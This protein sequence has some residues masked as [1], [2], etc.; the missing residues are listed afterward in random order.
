[1][2]L[3]SGWISYLKNSKIEKSELKLPGSYW[4][5]LY[6]PWTLSY[7]PLIRQE[8]CRNRHADGLLK[9]GLDAIMTRFINLSF[10]I[11]LFLLLTQVCRFH[12]NFQEPE[13][14]LL[15]SNR[16]KRC[17]RIKLQWSRKPT[18]L[19]KVFCIWIWQD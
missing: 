15:W 14:K 8:R 5:N 9:W 3:E 2:Y 4:M 7:N 17:F 6:P 18:G 11:I 12:I 10:L 19:K 16:L 13:I 1:L